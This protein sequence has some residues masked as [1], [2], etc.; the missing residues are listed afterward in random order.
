MSTPNRE[1]SGALETRFEE[2]EIRLAH[3]EYALQNQNEELLHLQQTNAMLVRQ[4]H[5]LGDRL[6]ALAEMPDSDP[7]AEPP[8]PHY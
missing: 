5:E 4:I 7:A 2:L 8:P 6:R 1:P 3:L